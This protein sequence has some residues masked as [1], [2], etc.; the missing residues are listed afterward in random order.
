ML[1]SHGC[2][3]RR[4]TIHHQYQY[5]IAKYTIRLGSTLPKYTLLEC[6]W[7]LVSL[8][9][10]EPDKKW[11][12][13]G[14]ITSRH[15]ML[16]SHGCCARRYTIHHQYIIAKYKIRLGSS[17][18]TYTGILYMNAPG[19]SWKRSPTRNGLTVAEYI[20]TTTNVI[21]ARLLRA[22]SRD[23]I[24]WL[25]IRTRSGA[26]GA[27]VEVTTCSRAAQPLYNRTVTSIP[28]DSSNLNIVINWLVKPLVIW[29]YL[30]VRGYTISTSTPSPGIRYD[31]A[32]LYQKIQYP[33]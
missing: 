3:V 19:I 26:G 1:S 10:A 30:T 6:T 7:Y 22:Y 5:T 13:R 11:V 20:W 27:S 21:V 25:I 28:I 2:C 15:R 12:D 29:V 23:R 18:P 14:L 33:T 31:L 9:G 32:Q 17:L 16:S 4:Y 24:V 8:V